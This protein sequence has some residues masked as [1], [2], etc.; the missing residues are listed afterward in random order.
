M[1]A[2]AITFAPSADA[3]STAA[4]PTPEPAPSTSTVSPG[5]MA[6]RQ[7]SAVQAVPYEIGMG[8]ALRSGKSSGTG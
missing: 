6:A 7:S 5:C 4:S 2:Q 8:S 1:L 3:I